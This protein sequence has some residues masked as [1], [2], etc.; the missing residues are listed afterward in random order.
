[1]KKPT[2][3]ER[4]TFGDTMMIKPYKGVQEVFIDDYFV[5]WLFTYQN[6]W[7]V[8][9]TEIFF[10]AG[11]TLEQTKPFENIKEYTIEES[12]D[13]G[14]YEIRLEVSNYENLLK[15]GILLLNELNK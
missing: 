4:L 14:F 9:I 1:M 15:L 5:G 3:I 12:E 10:S 6:N 11:L 8:P 7:L 13:I 2:G